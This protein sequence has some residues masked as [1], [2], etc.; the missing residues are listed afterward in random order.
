MSS[1]MLGSSAVSPANTVVQ[2]NLLVKGSITASSTTAP[3]AVISGNLTVGQTSTLTGAVAAGSTISSAGQITAGGGLSVPA[4]NL[5]VVATSNLGVVN[6]SGA[7]TVAGAITASG[8]TTV[9]NTVQVNGALTVAGNAQSNTLSNTLASP[10]TLLTQGFCPTISETI[11]LVNGVSNAIPLLNAYFADVTTPPRV[12][13]L[14]FKQL[15][16]GNASGS[17]TLM[18]NG[19]GF[20]GNLFN[21]SSQSGV[22]WYRDPNSAGLF[23]NTSGSVAGTCRVTYTFVV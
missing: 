14:T 18:Y 11:T 8:A 21:Y 5:S 7:L 9:N 17:A 12:I 13:Q 1:A 3:S 2:G 4:G 10:A 16:G 22:T 20:G 23:L 15:T 19:F 6:T